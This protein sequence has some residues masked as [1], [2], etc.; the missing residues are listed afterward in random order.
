MTINELIERLEFLKA[1][2]HGEAQLITDKSGVSDYAFASIDLNV[3][4]IEI[5]AN[6]RGYDDVRMDRYKSVGDK[7]V[8]AV[9]LIAY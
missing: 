9:E 8:N 4:S 1:K 2:G 5:K 7:D 6:S 3:A